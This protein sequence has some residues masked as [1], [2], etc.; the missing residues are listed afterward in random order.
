ML[1]GRCIECTTKYYNHESLQRC[2][3]KFNT[4]T[5]TTTTTNGNMEE[6]R[7][8]P[9]DGTWAALPPPI[10]KTSLFDEDISDL[11]VLVSTSALDSYS[12]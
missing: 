2:K 1:F 11:P 9:F 4:T 7:P 12:M 10:T 5:T 3:A 6:Y 8:I